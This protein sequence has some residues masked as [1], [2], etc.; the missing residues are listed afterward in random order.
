VS[1]GV[2]DLVIRRRE[3]C[4]LDRPTGGC[5]LEQPPQRLAQRGSSPEHLTSARWIAGGGGLE[6][7]RCHRRD[8][9]SLRGEIHEICV[10]LQV[11]VVRRSV[12][13]PERVREVEGE[14]ASDEFMWVV[15]C[16]NV[17]HDT[18]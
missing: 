17:A 15:G 10:L 9:A 12:R 2:P 6:L 1:E 4:R 8:R 3:I 18:P 14:R 16:G 7:A 5:G 13:T 11:F